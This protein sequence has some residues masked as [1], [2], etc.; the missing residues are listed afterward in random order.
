MG[1]RLTRLFN[2]LKR[3][4]SGK[5]D[6]FGFDSASRLFDSSDIIV[7]ACWSESLEEERSEGARLANGQM[8]GESE[9]DVSGGQKRMCLAVRRRRTGVRMMFSRCR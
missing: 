7:E 4:L 2:W 6:A 8:V 1:G 9:E 5:A 3:S